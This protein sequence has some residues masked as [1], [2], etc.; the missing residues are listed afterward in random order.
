MSKAAKRYKSY[1]IAGWYNKKML[2]NLVSKGKL[3]ADEYN[4]IT[5]EE[6]DDTESN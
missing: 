3:T 6:Y 2:K 4:E 1:Y 5:G